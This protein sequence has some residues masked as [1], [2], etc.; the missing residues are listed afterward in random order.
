MSQIN[1]TTTPISKPAIIYCGSDKEKRIRV[2]RNGKKYLFS[3]TAHEIK[4]TKNSG[5]RE[6]LPNRKLI[7]TTEGYA[8]SKLD[9]NFFALGKKTGRRFFITGK[10]LSAEKQYDSKLV[11]T[12][13]QTDENKAESVEAAN[14]PVI[15]V[16]DDSC[17]RSNNFL[18]RLITTDSPPV[19]VVDKHCLTPKTE[20]GADSSNGVVAQQRLPFLEGFS[21]PKKLALI[22]KNE[23][24]L[25]ELE[26]ISAQRAAGLD[27]DLKMSFIPDFVRES[28]PTL[29]R[30][31]GKSFPPPVKR[32]RGSYWPMS[33]I[34]MYK[35][36]DYKP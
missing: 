12:G 14:F 8:P 32:G 20:V 28:R 17:A 18:R 31:M 4:Q 3:G 33:L 36:G 13:P 10:L 5:E 11:I 25:R 7:V 29:Y 26:A 24:Y 15:Q 21:A 23:K 22:P 2:E 35:R 6:Q 30:K 9:K 16:K 27:P 1:S 34:E 19:D